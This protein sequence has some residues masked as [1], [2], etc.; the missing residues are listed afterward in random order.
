LPLSLQ[1]TKKT[2]TLNCNSLQVDYFQ[3]LPLLLQTTNKVALSV[4]MFNPDLG[5]G[6]CDF[7]PMFSTYL[8]VVLLVSHNKIVIKFVF[9]E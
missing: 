1:K 9:G 2:K 6:L 4:Y 3:F 8:S 5:G 7:N